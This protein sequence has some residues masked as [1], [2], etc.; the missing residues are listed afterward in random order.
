MLFEFFILGQ[1]I[2]EDYKLIKIIEKHL[3]P[4]TIILSSN[5]MDFNS[6]LKNINFE[7]L[8]SYLFEGNQFPPMP[9]NLK[10]FLQN[11][12]DYHDYKQNPHI[13]NYLQFDSS[14]G[15]NFTAEGFKITEERWQGNSIVK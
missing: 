4:K 5:I 8:E 7:K 2:E 15:I 3:R 11:S 1:N 10:V 9:G 13:Y 14:G 12:I 6:N